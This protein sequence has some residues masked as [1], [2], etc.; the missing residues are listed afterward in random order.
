MTAPAIHLIQRYPPALGGAESYFARLSEYLANQGDAVEVHTSNAL[1]LESFWKPDASRLPAR[2]EM[3]RGVNVQRHAIRHFP[4]RRY[5]L[6]ALSM[7]PHP[8]VQGFTLPASPQ[9]PSLL[10]LARQCNRPIR[11]V[12]ASAFP[13]TFPHYAGLL[14]ARRMG[15]PY[16]LTPF[17]HLGDHRQTNDRT[18][19]AYLSKPLVY[20]LRQ[21]DGVFV[22][23]EL[24]R[25]AVLQQGV[26]E[27]RVILQGLGVEPA[28]CTGGCR[29]R[30]DE[31]WSLPKNGPLRIGHLANLS[32]EKGS[33]DL[34]KVAVELT[35]KQVP[36]TLVLAGP[37]M[38]NFEAAWRQLPSSVTR[39][40]HRLGVLKDAEKPDFYASIDV[41]ALPSRSDSFGLVLLEAWTN[42]I[43]CVGYRAG[44]IAEVIR[45][46]SD[47]LLVPCGEIDGL[48]TALCQL[49]TGDSRRREFGE[50]G[51]QKVLK[52]HRWCDK[53]KMVRLLYLEHTRQSCTVPPVD[54]Q[55][56]SVIPSPCPS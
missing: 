40:I 23:T 34:L 56:Y 31:R 43:P 8:W 22:Q 15:V 10:A 30:A 29:Q 41:F 20:L 52:E 45:H 14:W 16:F 2:R 51:R 5:V 26:P 18:R 35:Q 49:L 25:Q 7:I 3:L 28:E 50:A 12:H 47:G 54:I 55:P 36:F 27:E 53:L 39:H 19:Q 9:L 13:Y 17:L 6:K 46:D 38:P 4:G 42:G 44:G 11:L 1:S 32:A 48:V 21:A 37:S 33:V 24:E